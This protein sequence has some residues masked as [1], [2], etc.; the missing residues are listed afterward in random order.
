M[1]RNLK[2]VRT[3]NLPDCWIGAGFIR[4]KV[5]DYLHEYIT[6]TPLPDID[7]IYFDTKDVDEKTEKKW[8]KLLAAKNPRVKWSVKNQARMHIQDGYEEPFTSTEDSLAEWSET[9]TSIAGRIN[10][11]DVI[12]LL[13]PHGIHD[14]IHLV[15]R[16][17]DSFVQ[18]KPEVYEERLR[19]K[20]W[21][22]K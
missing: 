7:V 21:K 2:F 3:L 5:W 4:S 22:K 9:A 1:I 19:K 14:L 8:E 17:I 18:R 16:P 20:E 11:N 12:E 10:D 13:T 6:P 15:V